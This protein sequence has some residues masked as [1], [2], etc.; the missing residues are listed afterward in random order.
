MMG[1]MGLTRRALLSLAAALP[2]LSIHDGWAQ[3]GG[4]QGKTIPKLALAL[5]VAAAEGEPVAD[6]AQLAEW[7]SEAERLMSPHGVTVGK[8]ESLVLPGEMARIENA[9]ERDA[10]AAE[11]HPKVVNAFIV[12]RLRDIDKPDRYIQGVRWRNRKNLS[13]DYVIVSAHA[14][15]TTLTHELGH[16]FGNGHSRVVNNIMSYERDDP[17]KIEFNKAQGA[18]M[19]VI[20]RR[21]L[22]AKRVLS[23]DDYEAS[24]ASG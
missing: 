17:A 12:E 7:L 19:R 9:L 2:V 5:H 3:Q 1:S 21:L 8:V 22:A 14:S 4:G 18:K 20:A 10:L 16:F 13:K 15:P 24:R 11:L 23:V 6:D